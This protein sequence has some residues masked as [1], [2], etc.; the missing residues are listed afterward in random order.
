MWAILLN[1]IYGLLSFFLSIRMCWERSWKIKIDAFWHMFI[2][3]FPKRGVPQNGWFLMENPIQIEDLGGT[4]I[5][6]NIHLLLKWSYLLLYSFVYFKHTH[7]IF[8]CFLTY[9]H[10]PTSFLTDLHHKKPLLG[11]LNLRSM[12]DARGFILH[13]SRGNL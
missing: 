9:L 12:V 13:G 8:T 3:V 10:L 6:G 4:P 2:W 1:I 5:F 7:I 11:N